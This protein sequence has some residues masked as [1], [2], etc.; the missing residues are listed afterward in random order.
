MRDVARCRSTA[1]GRPEPEGARRPVSSSRWLAGAG[2]AL[3]LGALGCEAHFSAAST[4]ASPV[5]QIPARAV[6]RG[7]SPA[8]LRLAR[9]QRALERALDRVSAELVRGP[10]D[11]VQLERRLD[12]V[13]ALLEI[14]RL[15]ARTTS[16]PALERLVL[17]SLPEG[18]DGGDPLA[19]WAST[20]ERLRRD[21]EATRTLSEERG[22]RSAAPPPADG[23]P[24]ERRGP[25]ILEEV[26]I[27]GR[28]PGSLDWEREAEWARA[29]DEVGDLAA[30]LAGGDHRF[31][32][33]MKKE[34]DRSS[35]APPPPPP[36]R[37]CPPGVPLCD[38]FLDGLTGVKSSGGARTR[39]TVLDVEPSTAQLA[40]LE[41]LVRLAQACVPAS[42]VAGRLS[43]RARLQG[44]RLVRPELHGIREVPL[45]VEACILEALNRVRVASM[46]EL[47]PRSIEVELSLR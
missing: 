36:A 13:L 17:A 45:F 2:V 40:E 1:L 34:V 7:A 38:G 27:E 9:E 31:K 4:V 24:R 11:E 10:T 18:V 20:V 16:D 32:S 47:S 15:I 33:A 29:D 19:R 14:D 42:T 41:R 21:G 3:A 30:L 35:A 22:A 25:I 26:A 28:A 12:L 8:A 46:T 43:V 39:A 6:D 44:G 37:S 23:T 5:R